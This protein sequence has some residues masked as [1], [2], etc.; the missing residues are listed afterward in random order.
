VFGEAYVALSPATRLT[1]GLRYTKDEKSIQTRTILLSAPG[2]FVVASRSYSRVTGRAA[3]DHEISYGDFG[4]SRL[5]AS[6]ARGY[7]AGGL[8]PGNSNTP[9]FA[10]ES[11]NA[12][13]IGAKNDLFRRTVQANLSA[14]YYDY[15]DLQ[16][17]QRVAGTAIT[18][19]G[20][21]RVWG[22]EGE[23]LFLP[24]PGLQLNANVSY[25]NTRIGD[26][27][28]VDAAN[29]AQVDPRTM[30]PATT[31]QVAVN[32]RGNELPYAPDFKL[33]VGA[34]YKMPLGGSG[35]SAMLR[36]DY[37]HQGSYFAR[38]FNTPNDRI[39]SWS[40]ANAFLRFSNADDTLNFELFVKNIG[41]S[42]AITSSIIEDAQVGSYRN[43]RVLEP[44]T[45]GIS[46]RLT[47]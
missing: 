35:W 4:E 23:F 30:P 41:D 33:N 38:E 43:V 42:D 1:F 10:P 36:G 16:L 19:N 6:V 25:L 8:N 20:D 22:L 45:Y 18:S 34:Q 11:L 9:E 27:S 17:G 2:P 44:R 7:K 12:F 14:F 5:Y 39:K 28:T 32:L 40:I 46:T 47:F 13:E 3:I 29:P 21:A 37:V 26:F 24:T 31:P 15:N